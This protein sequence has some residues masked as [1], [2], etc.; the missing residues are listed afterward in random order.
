MMCA[1]FLAELGLDPEEAIARVR[2]ARPN[3]IRTVA[4]E[5]FVRAVASASAS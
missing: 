1:R 5:D 2:Q 3:A 4:Q